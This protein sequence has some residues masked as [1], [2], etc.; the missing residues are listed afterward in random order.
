MPCFKICC[1]TLKITCCDATA[2][3]VEN[4]SLL[5]LGLGL[6]SAADPVVSRC[7][8][9][10]G[11]FL[12]GSRMACS[13]QDL[14]VSGSE[15]SLNSSKSSSSARAISTSTSRDKS[16]RVHDRFSCWSFHSTFSADSTALNWGMQLA[17]GP[18][19]TGQRCCVR[20]SNLAF[21]FADTDF[22]YFD[23]N[24]VMIV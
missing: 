15:D 12:R 22:F 8:L 13:D 2:S 23:D 9:I 1:P 3:R 24:L 5:S 18:L 16:A 21:D 7:E 10:R 11:N 6:G 14:P 4:C 19:G 17:A 20:T